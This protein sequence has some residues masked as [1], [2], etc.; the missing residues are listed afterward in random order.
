MKISELN[1]EQRRIFDDICERVVSKN[2]NEHSFYIFISGEA[3]TGKSHV[4]RLLFEA[5]KIIQ[6][7]PGDDIKKP[8]V[9][10]TAPTA[11]AAFII[12]G[13]TIDSCLGF[14]FLDKSHYTQADPGRMSMMKF[15]YE[16]VDILFI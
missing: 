8:V 4:V 12:G 16:D 1:F 11:N 14:N 9:L 3:G 7:R 2:I 5:V 10:V 6:T 13:K 15:L